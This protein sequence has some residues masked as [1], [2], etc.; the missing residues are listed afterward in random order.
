MSLTRHLNYLEIAHLSRV[1]VMAVAY[2]GDVD[3]AALERA[4]ALLCDACPA[5]RART[6][7]AGTQTVLSVHPEH[8]PNLVTL[9]CDVTDTGKVLAELG[10]LP[11]DPTSSMAELVLIPG[12]DHG[13]LALRVDHAIA[14]GGAWLGL[15]R[16]LL[17]LLA[18]IAE[19]GTPAC[20]VGDSLPTP[21]AEIFHSRIGV[22]PYD[23]RLLY[24]AAPAGPVAA[25]SP[26]VISGYI[27]LTESETDWLRASARRYGTSVHGLVCG[28][29]LAGQRALG[30]GAE[31]ERMFCVSP[32]DFRNRL[33]PP[34]GDLETTNLMLSYLTEVEVS[35][36]TSPVTIGA[37]IKKQLDEV[38]STMTGVPGVA[39]PPTGALD[40]NLTFAL[41]S[42]L[43]VV[44]P[45][46]EPAG[47]SITDL[48][49][50]NTVEDTM[51]PG[52]YVYTY[53]GT[54]RIVY[55]LT[56]RFF[57]P[58]MVESLTMQIREQLLVAGASS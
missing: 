35:P 10:E 37:S 16:E 3:P 12:E 36:R 58:A 31:P 20:V 7:G 27:R 44:D 28:A 2:R 9:S 5:L 30:G 17:R 25:D 18:E 57:S 32:V 23:R 34:V 52:Y 49:I 19:G 14:D 54:L 46:P 1:V 24:S 48:H 47:V 45:L 33:S 4:F 29:I 15:F 6:S 13:F 39:T 50:V 41:V 8:R 51:F 56:S 38:L 40:H 11:W 43:G 42:N 21:P 55:V 22:I 26:G 53:G